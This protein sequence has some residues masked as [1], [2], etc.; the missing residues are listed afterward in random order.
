MSGNLDSPTDPLFKGYFVLFKVILSQVIL[1][2]KLLRNTA[3]TH[4]FKDANSFSDLIQECL[5]FTPAKV[6]GVAAFC[7]VLLT[8]VNAKGYTSMQTAQLEAIYGI[9]TL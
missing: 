7:L 9:L 6:K 1:I 4:V 8:Q 2:E 3:L 5:G